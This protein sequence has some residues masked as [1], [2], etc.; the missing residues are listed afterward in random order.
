[1]TWFILWDSITSVGLHTGRRSHHLPTW[2]SPAWL[3]CYRK[4]SSFPFQSFRQKHIRA[5]FKRLLSKTMHTGCYPSLFSV[6]CLLRRE[7]WR[8]WS[9]CSCLMTRGWLFTYFHVSSMDSNLQT[10]LVW[11]MPRFPPSRP[12]FY[13]LYLEEPDKSGHSY[14]PDSGGVSS[15][16]ISLVVAQLKSLK[17][18]R[19]ISINA[20][21]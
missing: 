7:C 18:R 9:G 20:D 10:S 8:C 14:G 16:Q 13:T 1:M 21:R 3:V 6:K 2:L 4:A 5:V 12:D 17:S 11:W 19:N 15:P